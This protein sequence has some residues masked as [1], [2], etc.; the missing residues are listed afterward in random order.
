MEYGFIDNAN[1]QQRL[2]NDLLNYVEGVVR[3]VAN[4]G[5]YP[6]T[7]PKETEEN[8][9]TVKKGD[10]LW[11]IA[12]DFGVTVQE[13]RDINN[14]TSDTL[15]IGQILKIPGVEII[16]PITDTKTYIVQRGDRIFMGNN[17]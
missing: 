11:S 10:S 6:Y 3:A 15:Q 1:D 12:R 16:P 2:Q 5:G 14:L 7:P 8:Y 4:Y 17:E 9:Y 13:L